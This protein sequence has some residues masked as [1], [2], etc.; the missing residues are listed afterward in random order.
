MFTQHSSIKGPVKQHAFSTAD[1]LTCVSM[2]T[3]GDT[4]NINDGSVQLKQPLK[5]EQLDGTEPSLI[6]LFTPVLF[7][8]ANAYRNKNE[9]LQLN[10]QPA[11]L[12]AFNSLG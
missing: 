6:S 8:C 11:H 10:K 3:T 2:K 4:N 5:S 7:F 1:I 12:L 9:T